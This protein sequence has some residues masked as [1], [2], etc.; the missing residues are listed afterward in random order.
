MEETKKGFHSLYVWSIFFVLITY[1]SPI[2][3][4]L[5]VNMSDNGGEI[6]SENKTI[7]LLP[8]IFFL[9]PVFLLVI[10]VLVAIVLKKTERR[11]FLN[12]AKII[13]YA[14][15]PFFIL[16]SILILL[17]ILMIFTPVVIMMFVG[18]MLVIIFSLSGWMT[19]VG[20]APFMIAYLIQA[21]KEGK[22][23]ESFAILIILMQFFF[24]LDVIGMI[25]CSVKERMK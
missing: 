9:M 22:Y 4:I 25:I 11:I 1:I 7:E 18:P 17:C 20:S 14:L 12:C 3:F 13:K 8:W 23:K 21:K 5:A 16:G 15:I 10:N 2:L 19:L 6:Q 24:V